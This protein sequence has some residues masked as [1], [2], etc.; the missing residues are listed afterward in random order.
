MGRLSK[1]VYAAALELLFD[2][3]F[4]LSDEASEEIANLL[5]SPMTER[6]KVVKPQ[7]LKCPWPKGAL[8]AY[9][10]ASN[11]ACKDSRFWNQYV[12][13]RIIDIKKWPLSSI[14]PCLL[15]DES[16]YVA[17]YN[18]VGETLPEAS[19]IANLEF[20]PISFRKPILARLSTDTDCSFK[21]SEF[22]YGLDWGSKKNT[23]AIFT[24]IHDYFD[25]NM[26][27]DLGD[28]KT[29]IP[30]MIGCVGF[31]SVLIKRLEQLFPQ[32][33]LESI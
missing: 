2:S 20:T 25:T 22:I 7:T 18:W 13:L 26:F 27:P 19:L 16:M 29:K 10:I 12:L 9:R 28:Q 30:P 23:K 33:D 1:R 24:G 5:V 11:V 6:K 15:C 31:D 14:A 4:V 3:R 8:L 32:H 17:L 21:S